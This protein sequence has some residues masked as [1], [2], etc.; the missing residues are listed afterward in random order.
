MSTEIFN[1]F[2]CIK[3]CYID[4]QILIFHFQIPEYSDIHLDITNSFDDND[5]D[6]ISIPEVPIPP[7]DDILKLPRDENFSLYIPK[8][9]KIAGR[10][11]DIF[12]GKTFRFIFF[13]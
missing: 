2:F 11:I 6:V 7:L 10:L 13:L 12:L 9:R 1:Y 5:Y 3:L 8:H 4:I